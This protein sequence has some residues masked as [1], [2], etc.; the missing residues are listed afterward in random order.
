MVIRHRNR[1]LTIVE[2]IAAVTVLGVAL[3]LL[4]PA[5]AMGRREAMNARCLANLEDLAKA[6]A[7]Y[8]ST[9]PGELMIPVH[10]RTFEFSPA[11]GQY[12][13]GGKSGVGDPVTGAKGGEVDSL[14]GT[15]FGRGPATRGLNAVIYRDEFEDFTDNPGPKNINWIND[16]TLDLDVYRCPADSG[17]TGMHYSNWRDSGLSSYDHY[18]TSYTASTMWVGAAGGGCTLTSNSTFMRSA[19]Q[20]PNAAESILFMENNGRNAWRQNYG[21]DGCGFVSFCGIAGCLVGLEETVG[22]W[23]GEDWVFNTAFV[24]GHASAVEMRGH[25]QPQPGMWFPPSLCNELSQED[26]YLLW[27]CTIIRGPG[28]QIDTLPSA[29]VPSNVSCSIAGDVIPA[30]E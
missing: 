6:T 9:D 21:A 26:C 7:T 22:G 8:A 16:T 18:G 28:W 5:L 27:R 24:D 30:G 19:S 20:V 11:R 14:W 12:E 1:G 13:W 2:L 3:T 10:P 17:Y 4:A 23:H 15:Q 25:D 29:P